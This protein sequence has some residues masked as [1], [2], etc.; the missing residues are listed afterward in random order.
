MIQGTLDVFTKVKANLLPTPVSPHYIFSLHDVARVLN[1]VIIRSPRAKP[2][3]AA[4]VDA[5]F[6]GAESCKHTCAL[7]SY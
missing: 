2:R 3:S 5:L 7:N 4:E 6:A 1:A